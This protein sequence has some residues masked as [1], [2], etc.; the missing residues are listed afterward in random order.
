MT[1]PKRTPQRRSRWDKEKAVEFGLRLRELREQAGLS[2][3]ELSFDG[4]TAAYI[5]R[6]EKGERY[7]SVV[8]MRGLADRLRISADYLETG[9]GRPQLVDT[10]LQMV[11]VVT[12]GVS[13][14]SF[15]GLA[16]YG[17]AEVN[18]KYDG[19][20][21]TAEGET[22]NDALLNAV[23]WAQKVDRLREA[24]AAREVEVAEQDAE[25]ER[26]LSARTVTG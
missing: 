25:L 3:R 1:T 11:D 13:C 10:L 2:Q 12:E 6:V 19:E 8:L 18:F 5:S 26:L 4:C 22:L 16:V 7:P 20:T 9:V 24:A 14:I 23:Q 15:R 21:R 17:P